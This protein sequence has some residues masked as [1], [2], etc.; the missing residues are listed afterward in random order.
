MSKVVNY[1]D[2]VESMPRRMM[3]KVLGRNLKIREYEQYIWLSLLPCFEDLTSEE[4]LNLLA[5]ENKYD[6][7]MTVVRGYDNL[8]YQNKEIRLENEMLEKIITQITNDPGVT[9]I[10]SHYNV[11]M[12][13][14]LAR[15]VHG[16]AKSRPIDY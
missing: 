13:Q 6:I 10:I 7:V 9:R 5:K 8:L 2:R 3:N 16:L 15:L 4:F 12:V 1:N 14:T 11:D